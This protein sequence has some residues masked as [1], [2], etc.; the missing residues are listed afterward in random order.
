MTFIK[1]CGLR[2]DT[3]VDVLVRLGVDAIGF[4]FADS[5][6]R[7]SPGD[8]APL[9][10]RVTGATTAVGVFKGSSVQQVIEVAAEAG[11][12]TVQV[13]DLRSREDVSA[14]RDAGLTVIRAVVAGD[15]S[16]DFGADRLLVD[17]ADAGAG[18]PWDWAATSRPEGEWILAGGLDPGNVRAAIDATGAWGVDVSSGVESSRGVKDPALIEQFVTAVRAQG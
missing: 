2:D 3:S 14:L 6:R 18:V 15:T 5:A 10:S 1:V 16:G 12:H 13:H 11:L 4:V 8:A 17:G 7:I 9:V